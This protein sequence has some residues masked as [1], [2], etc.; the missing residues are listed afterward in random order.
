MWKSKLLKQTGVCVIVVLALLLARSVNVPQLNRGSEAAIAYLSK[1]Y[2]VSD[3]M[4][5][6]KN[7]IATIA[8]TPVTVTNAVLSTKEEGKYGKPADEAKE[9]ETVSVYAV[10]AGTIS[11]VG[12]NEKIGKFIKINHGDEAESIYGNCTSIY[13]KELDRVKKGQV[14]ATFKKEPDTEFYYSFRNL[15]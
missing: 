12:E 4:T 6:A 10:G 5:F 2:T 14:I 9:G 13:V 7:S 11:A 1:N 15:D 3:A 8:K